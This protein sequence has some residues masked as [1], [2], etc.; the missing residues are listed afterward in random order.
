MTTMRRK[1]A[2]RYSAKVIPKL[3]RREEERIVL[4]MGI[5][6]YAWMNVGGIM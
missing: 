2:C 3:P 5:G 6:R 1:G 4:D